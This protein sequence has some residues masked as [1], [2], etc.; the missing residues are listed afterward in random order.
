[1]EIEVDRQH[2]FAR[3]YDRDERIDAGR[4]RLRGRMQRLVFRPLEMAVLLEF[5]GQPSGPEGGGMLLVI[6]VH[7]AMLWEPK[8]TK[9]GSTVSSALW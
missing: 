1:M 6:L 7:S 9:G 8:K 5:K 3:V 4:K 2:Q